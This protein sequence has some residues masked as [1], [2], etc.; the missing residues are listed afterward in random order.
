MNKNRHYKRGPFRK[1]KRNLIEKSN[2]LKSLRRHSL[3]VSLRRRGRCNLFESD[4]E[5]EIR[6][7][8]NNPDPEVQEMVDKARLQLDRLATQ[9][10][11]A[12]KYFLLEIYQEHG[13][14][15]DQ[16]RR[17]FE[18]TMLIIAKSERKSELEAEAELQKL[19]RGDNK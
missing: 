4:I 11:E 9:E 16:L 13:M 12:V 17:A 3:V 5:K 15:P 8:T 2:Y 1:R 7:I 6:R 18:E 14:S 19:E 10:R